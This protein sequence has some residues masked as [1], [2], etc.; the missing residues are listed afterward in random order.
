MWGICPQSKLMVQV[1]RFVWWASLWPSVLSLSTT[2]CCGDSLRGI[3]P[4][5][6]HCCGVVPS[7]LPFQ[8]G[9]MQGLHMVHLHSSHSVL[10]VQ[11]MARGLSHPH[12]YT[13]LGWVLLG[14]P[15]G[16]YSCMYQ[17]VSMY[18][19]SSSGLHDICVSVRW[20]EVSW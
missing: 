7:S 13:P 9:T 5:F 2:D 11:A 8:A 10:S 12:R 15:R 20:H 14:P 1:G 16:G 18:N 17:D 4:F 6:L 19:V 3:L